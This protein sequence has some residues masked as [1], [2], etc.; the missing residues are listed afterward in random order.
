MKLIQV[1]ALYT[2]RTTARF[3]PRDKVPRAAV[4]HPVS[5]RTCQPTLAG[6]DNTGAVSIPCGK[7]LRN[8][9]LVMTDLALM[10]AVHIGGIEQR[11]TGVERRL[12]HGNCAR[13]VAIA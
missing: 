9:P 7:R 3:A 11:H 13:L 1:D 2:E 6:D 4:S 10:P 8:Q 12:Q 5:L